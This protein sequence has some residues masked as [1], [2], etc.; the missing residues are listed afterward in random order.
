MLRSLNVRIIITS[1]ETF[2][3][4][5]P[6][7]SHL[8]TINFIVYAL[9]RIQ[10]KLINKSE[11][12]V[13]LRYEGEFI[14]RLYNLIKKKIIRVNNIHF[15][16]KRSLIV[17]P[18]EKT[19]VYKSSTKRQ[20]LHILIFAVEKTLNKQRITNISKDIVFIMKLSTTASASAINRSR[21]NFP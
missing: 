19:N 20:R 8:R 10:K 15:V 4:R 18:E 14:F 6:I 13:L 5:K 1:F 7:L 17:N 9:K 2:H 3:H 21:S 12:C 16:E 11:K